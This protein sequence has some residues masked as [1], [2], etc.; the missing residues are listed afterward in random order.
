[1]KAI[2]K[3]AAATLLPVM[4]PLSVY[5]AGQRE[6]EKPLNIIFF[7]VDDMGYGDLGY[8][9]NPVVDSPNIDAFAESATVFTAGYAA[10]E[11]SPTRASLLTGKN[12]AR[13]HITTWITQPNSRKAMTY[14]GWKMPKEENGVPL[15]EYLVS[16]ALRDNGYDTWHVG[17]W[18]I[19][20][21]PLSPKKQGF[22]TEIAYWPWSFPKS[23]VSP[24]NLPT[25]ENGPDGEYLTDRLTDEAVNLI[26]N[27]GDKPFFLNLWHYGVHGPLRAREDYLEYYR[28]KGLPEDGKNQATYTAMKRS[29]DDSFGRILKAVEDAGIADNTV[30]V[31]FT[32]NGGTIRHADNGALRMGKKFLYEGGIRV[33][34]IIRAPGLEKGTVDIPVSSIDFYPTMLHWAGIDRN[35]V[36]QHLDGR[37]I[38]DLLADGDAYERPLFWHEVG[39]FGTGPTTAMRKGD[40]KLLH[41]YARPEGSQYELYDLRN[42]ISESHDIAAEHHDIVRSMAAEMEKWLKENNAQMPIPPAK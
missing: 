8:L 18:H 25:I 39:A 9:G 1:M 37:D 16:E 40:Y 27:H 36:D 34:L 31:F 24:Y 10:P 28:S 33:P 32:D 21:E 22:E 14:K 4:L 30:I 13:L 15:S 42:D 2:K 38:H 12:P 7:L 23:Y 3:T 19:G 41:F 35:M 20:E 29:I 26:M 5:A 17:K 11:S 6:Q